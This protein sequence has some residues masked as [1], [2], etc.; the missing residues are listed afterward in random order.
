MSANRLFT[1][2]LSIAIYALAFPVC[3]HAAA[4]ELTAKITVHDARSAAEQMQQAIQCIQQMRQ[5]QTQQAR[6]ENFAAAVKNLEI[7]QE[8]WPSHTGPVLQSA[9]MIA[10]LSLE[11]REPANA[12][13]ALQK[14]E[15]QA[16][17]TPYETGIE[18]RLANA[19]EML[20]DNASAEQ[21]YS[22]AEKAIAKNTPL[23]EKTAA[24][25]QFARYYAR[26]GN[27]GEAATRLHK[28]AMSPGLDDVQATTYLVAAAEEAFQ[29]GSDPRHTAGAEELAALDA[30]I[31]AARAHQLAPKDGTFIEHV[32]L[33]AQRLRNRYA[34]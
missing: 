29:I 13:D 18:R 11:W 12:R 26:R 28:L 2:T 20:N 24:L 30:R 4:P 7:L 10:D 6:F 19:F 3:G 32:A 25:S 15:K 22:A 34:L 17:A 23:P 5:S 16:T 27:H 31:S 8:H 21:H 9:I 14:V 1:F 33:Q